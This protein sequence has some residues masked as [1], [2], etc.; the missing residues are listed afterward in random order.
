MECVLKS[1]MSLAMCF[2]QG[3]LIRLKARV[4]IATAKTTTCSMV[5]YSYC[6][7]RVSLAYCEVLLLMLYV[8]V[9]Q[10]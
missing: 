9:L 4:T 5:N 10:I 7:K 3:G 6:K 8:S 1:G 2:S